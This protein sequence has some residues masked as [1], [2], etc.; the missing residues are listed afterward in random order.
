MSGV[1]AELG[2]VPHLQDA[3]GQADIVS[4]ATMAWQPVIISDWVRPGTRVDLIGAFKVDDAL[5]AKTALFVD[6]RE[7]TLGHMGELMIPVASGAI[8]V[9]S[10]LGNL[11]DLVR[12]DTR[13]RQPPVEITVFKNGGGAHLD[14]MI[15]SYIARAMTV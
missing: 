14:L 5:M 8:T 2:T 9:E 3:P 4:L 13:R 6:S 15:A 11:Y 7:T 12:R 10:V 1:K